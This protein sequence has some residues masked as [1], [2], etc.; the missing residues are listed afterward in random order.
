MNPDPHDS[1]S[2]TEAEDDSEP[3]GLDRWILP[4]LTDSALWPVTLVLLATLAMFGAAILLMALRG[5]NL[6]AVA[7][8]VILAVGSFETLFRSVRRRR[9]G[10]AGIL[11]PSLWLLAALVAFAAARYGLF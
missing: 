1:P 2:E 4:Y 5:R 11:I 10:A 7:A 3:R 8:L 6:F 9:L